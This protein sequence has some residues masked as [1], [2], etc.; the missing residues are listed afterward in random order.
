MLAGSIHIGDEP[1]NLYDHDGA[2]I[3]RYIT[4]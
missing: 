1:I 4:V 2:L 3:A